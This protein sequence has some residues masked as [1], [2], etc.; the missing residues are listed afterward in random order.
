MM[1]RVS[2]PKADSLYPLDTPPQTETE[3]VVR[4]GEKYA[5]Q[6]YC[7]GGIFEHLW[8]FVA[9]DGRTYSDLLAAMDK[10]CLLDTKEEA[11]SVLNKF[12]IF[13]TVW[14]R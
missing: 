9:L 10:G 13:E 2:K 3:R 1:A 11:I 4:V 12:H 6:R 14:T 8:V 7:G 5:P